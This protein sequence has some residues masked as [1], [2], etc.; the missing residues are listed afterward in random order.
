MNSL[1]ARYRIL[2]SRQLA[3]RGWIRCLIWGLVKAILEGAAF[4]FGITNVWMRVS[5]GLIW[6]GIVAAAVIL[7]ITTKRSLELLGLEKR[8]RF[9]FLL[10]IVALILL[11]IQLPLLALAV[12]FFDGLVTIV[13]TFLFV[14]SGYAVSARL[15]DRD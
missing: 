10:Q 9:F 8:L 6:L 15:R 7:F 4:F 5:I 12:F 3:R 1:I 11:G 14:I 13:S 2:V